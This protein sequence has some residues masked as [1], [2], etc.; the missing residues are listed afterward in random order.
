MGSRPATSLSVRDYGASRGSHAHAHFQVLVG[1]QG[2]L[3]LEV[4]GRGQ[5]V[6][7]GQGV[8]VAP[9]ERHDFEAA[10]P[11][12]SRCLVL[13][14]SDAV[15]A[16]R[17]GQAPTDARVGALARYLALSLERETASALALLQGPALLRE[18]WGPGEALARGHRPIDWLALAAWLRTH[19]HLPLTV[20]DLARQVHLSPGQFSERCR[21]HMGVSPMQ[22]LRGQRLAQ[23][24]ALRLGGMGV[25]EAA[26][27]TGYRSPSALTAAMR[28]S[29]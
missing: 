15:W 14:T 1:L 10:A 4:E 27:R 28:R 20:A 24:R 8:V 13:D 12:G 22:W 26:R 7:E 21:Q 17:A 23:A 3:E 29:A 25:A 11:G 5:R 9:G 16:A 6:G 18:A 19:W 2:V